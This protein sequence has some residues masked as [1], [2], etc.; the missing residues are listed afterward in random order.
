MS[1]VY[2]NDTSPLSRLVP[3]PSQVFWK[4][5]VIPNH[6]Q[7]FGFKV[8]TCRRSSGDSFCFRPVLL[9]LMTDFL[10]ESVTM[11]LCTYLE[12]SY[13]T[14]IEVYKVIRLR[15]IHGVLHHRI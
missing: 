1:F 5:F 2:D 7:D 11:S 12:W 13:H 4:P 3:D 14:N 15:Y 10:R 6:I 8:S 9:R